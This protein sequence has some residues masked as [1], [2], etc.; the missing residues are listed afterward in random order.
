MLTQ[1]NGASVIAEAITQWPTVFVLTEDYAGTVEGGDWR[2]THAVG[3]VNV[4]T[5]EW[6][7]A[8]KVFDGPNSRTNT[9][10]ARRF[11]ALYLADY[12]GAI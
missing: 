1:V 9:G 10:A 5:G 3:Y 12:W 6:E 2:M 8:P 7:D 11:Y 4:E